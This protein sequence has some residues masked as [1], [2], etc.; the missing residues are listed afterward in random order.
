MSVLTLEGG[1][2]TVMFETV[3][4]KS[5]KFIL[6]FNDDDDDGKGETEDRLD[7]RMAIS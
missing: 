6:P 4:F 5:S 2:S 3:F 1:E 7:S